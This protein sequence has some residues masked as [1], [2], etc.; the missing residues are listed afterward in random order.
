MM[1]RGRRREETP[2]PSDAPMSRD[3]ATRRLSSLHADWRLND[4]ATRLTRRF[5]FKGYAGPVHTANLVAWLS[6][7]QGHH[8]DVEFGWGYCVV[9]Y[10][11]HDVGGLSTLDFDG[12]A[13]LDALVT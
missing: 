10:T 7:R 5:A 9:H 1:G 12:A 4:A 2:M 6:D 8:A 3:E 13:K 11:T